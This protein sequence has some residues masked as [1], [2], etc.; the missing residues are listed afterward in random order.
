M[1]PENSVQYDH[2]ITNPDNFWG[3]LAATQLCWRKPFDTVSDCNMHEG[4]HRWFLGGK[5]N[6]TGKNIRVFLH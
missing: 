4:Q 5:I 2:S 3:Q 6:V 1:S